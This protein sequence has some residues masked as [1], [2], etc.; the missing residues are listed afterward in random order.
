MT[1]TAIGVLDLGAPDAELEALL[2]DAWARDDQAA[3]SAIEAE[4]DRRDRA[5]K[6]RERSR[7]AA[8]E[9][10]AREGREYADALHAAV[11]AASAYCRGRLFSREGL[12]EGPGTE[13][14]LWRC[15]ARQAERWASE[16]LREW[17][18]VNGRLTLAEFRA[19][20]ASSRR[21]AR[22]QRDAER[23]A[24]RRA[25]EAAAWEPVDGGHVRPV[26]VTA[27]GQRR[28]AWWARD[29]A[30]S[31][32]LH[33]TRELATG[34]PAPTAIPAPVTTV[35]SAGPPPAGNPGLPGGGYIAAL[36]AATAAASQVASAYGA[37]IGRGEI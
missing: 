35:P 31:I 5:A 20:L 17:W 15:T 8:A 18:H 29:H 26:W 36:T 10:H 14:G 33:P 34:T 32:S 30:G 12:A 22:E 21:A 28:R 13:E 2:V 7:L 25:A 16:E 23:D 6:A 3:A 1:G 19:G 24:A 11:L 4:V 27:G 9:F 37:I